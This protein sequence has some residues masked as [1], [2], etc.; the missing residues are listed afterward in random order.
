MD[1]ETPRLRIESDGSVG[2][3][4]IFLGEH[5]IT[6]SVSKIVWTHAGGDLPTAEV[7]FLVDAL[8]AEVIAGPPKAA[9]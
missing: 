2:G 1:R 5:E 6:H 9:R 8:N 4:R 7:T 3:T